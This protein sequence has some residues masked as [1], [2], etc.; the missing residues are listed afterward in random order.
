M[1][2]GLLQHEPNPAAIDLLLAPGGLREKAGE[3]G[4]VRAVEDAATHIGQALVGQDDQSGQIV[5]KMP[6]LALVLKQIAKY[7][8]VRSDDGS[9][10][11]NRQFHHTPPCPGLRIQ[12]G[13]RVAWGSRHGKSQQPSLLFEPNPEIFKSIQSLEDSTKFGSR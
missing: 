5:L 6:K 13:P 2:I 1:G 10:G 11:N 4:F 3:V 9:R 8:C 7:H 12:R